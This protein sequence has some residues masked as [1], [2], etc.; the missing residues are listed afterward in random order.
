MKKTDNYMQPLLMKLLQS[1]CIVN[2]SEKNSL[3]AEK[4]YE[5]N[6]SYKIYESLDQVNS[7]VT[8]GEGAVIS[9][10]RL[11]NDENLYV[12]I[13]GKKTWKK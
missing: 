5:R 9:G 3:H 6:P 1:Q 10:I 12:C 11:A 13:Y 8:A 4:V 2:M 7:K